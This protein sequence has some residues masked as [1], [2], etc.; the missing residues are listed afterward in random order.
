[1]AEKKLLQTLKVDKIDINEYLNY[2]STPYEP[3]DKD[4]GG[5]VG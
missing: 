5:G 1:M 2:S 4:M 3:T